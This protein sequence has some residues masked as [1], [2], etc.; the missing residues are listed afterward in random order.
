M[1]EQPER[2]PQAWVTATCGF[3]G[4]KSECYIA[5]CTHYERRSGSGRS[6]W[7]QIVCQTCLSVS[8]VPMSP[9]GIDWARET[10]GVTPVALANDAPNPQSVRRVKP[11]VDISTDDVLDFMTVLRTTD[12]K[13]LFMLLTGAE[14]V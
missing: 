11:L 2:D 9:T 1:L 10:L 5:D 4:C 6:C 8:M 14:P 13:E 12:D 7:T 3:C